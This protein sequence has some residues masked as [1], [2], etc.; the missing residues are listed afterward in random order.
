MEGGTTHAMS[1]FHTAIDE[2]SL[3]L[4]FAVAGGGASMLALGLMLRSKQEL[5][6]R[7]LVGTVLH[8]TAWG[9]AVFLMTVD[10]AGLGLPMVLGLSI[11]SG[12]GL[13]SFIDVILLLMRQRMGLPM[14]GLLPPPQ[15]PTAEQPRQE[16]P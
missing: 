7:V 10:N 9:V 14:P 5:T 11:F 4:M 1:K 6:P 16:Q 8:T 12:M 2:A 13:A 3:W 15:Q